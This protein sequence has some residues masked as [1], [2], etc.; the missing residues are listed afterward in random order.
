MTEIAQLTLRSPFD[1][2]P[3]SL[4]GPANDPGVVRAIEASGGVYEPGVM[5]VLAQVLRPDSVVVDV[6]ANIGAIALVMSRLTP[7]G[8]VYAF[9]P[10][11]ETFGY[12]L[13]NLQDNGAGNVVAEQCAVYD[14]TGPVSFVFTPASP[15][16][17]FVSNEKDAAAWGTP[18][19]AVR[20]DDY[21]ARH[22]IERVDLIMVDAEGAEPAVLRGARQTIETHDPVLLVEVNPVCLRQFGQGGFRELLSVIGAGRTVL[23]IDAEGT[24]TRLLNSRQ[25]DRLL[26]REGVINVLCLPRRHPRITPASMTRGSAIR[27][28]ARLELQFNRWRPPANSFVFEPA[29]RLTVN[30]GAVHGTAGT[31]VTVPVQVENTGTSWLSS[32][33]TYPV[34]VGSGWLDEGL[35]EWNATDR[36]RLAG[37]LGPGRSATVSLPVTL[38]PAPGTY[39]LAVFMV[40]DNF[41]WFHLLDAT[42]RV[43][44]VVEVSPGP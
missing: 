39:Q 30:P 43:T 31:T 33:F 34:Q 19:A 29:V 35:P 1:P 10:A 17:S 24:L 5:K 38:P 32:D 9:E 7:Q 26:R 13:R 23:F 44:L 25:A 22:G 4:V 6:G 2:V 14:R 16:G 11:P 15:A 21:A 12:L 27:Q 8:R 40:Q 37:P 20:L 3:Y 36:G 28:M 42:T 18:V 41:S